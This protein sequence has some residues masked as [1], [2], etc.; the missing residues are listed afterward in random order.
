MNNRIMRSLNDLYNFVKE[1]TSKWK[2]KSFFKP[3]FRGQTN[4][5]YLLLPSILRKGNEDKEFQITKKFRLVAPGFEKTPDTNRIDQW[6]FLMQHL[7]LPTRLLDWTES[8]LIA[9]FFATLKANQSEEIEN[10]ASIYLLDPL[11]LNMK[12][13]GIEDFPV[14]WTQNEVLQTIKFAFGTQNERVRIDGVLKEIKYSEL[15]IAVFP[16]TVHSR[17]K[18]QKGCFTLHGND[19][20]DLE[21]QLNN[22]LVKDKKLVK[23]TIQKDDIKVIHQELNNMGI[24]YSTVFPDFDG[25][26]KELKYEF[27]IN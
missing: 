8:P 4:S 11:E 12:S 25:L 27:G 24:T 3:W 18:A 19:K 6:L 9:A 2:R 21:T 22:F 1:D 5:K 13:I 10:D 16:S 23:Y 7:E 26:V 15:P 14:T 20:R 17:M